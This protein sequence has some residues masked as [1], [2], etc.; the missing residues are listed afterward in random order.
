MLIVWGEPKRLAN[1]AKH[2]LDFAALDISYFEF[3]LI[4]KARSGRY[5]ALGFLG[6]R[7]LAVVFA[8]LGT[9]A[10]SVISMRAASA[11]ERKLL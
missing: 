8:P 4:G 1:I 5:K 3:A 10:V 7:A 11:S 6:D 2:G 9:E